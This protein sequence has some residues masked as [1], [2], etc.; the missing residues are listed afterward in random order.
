MRVDRTHGLFCEC[1]WFFSPIIANWRA[2][3]RWGDELRATMH[4]D[5]TTCG[6]DKRNEGMIVDQKHMY[7][8]AVLGHML[9]ARIAEHLM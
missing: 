4:S 1:R 2:C 6:G 5:L 3:R 8:S 9:A 7:R